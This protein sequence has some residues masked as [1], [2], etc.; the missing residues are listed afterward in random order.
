MVQ[1]ADAERT[2]AAQLNGLGLDFFQGFIDGRDIPFGQRFNQG[3]LRMAMQSCTS[4]LNWAAPGRS[5]GS[6]DWQ[7]RKA[8]AANKLIRANQGLNR[9][10]LRWQLLVSM[11]FP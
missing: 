4:F 8:T 3:G 5:W 11:F 9:G 1:D 10:T 2:H 7:P 6:W